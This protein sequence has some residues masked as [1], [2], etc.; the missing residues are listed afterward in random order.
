[1]STARPRAELQE[2]LQLVEQDLTQLRETAAS[3]RGR[4]GERWD[5]PTDS[6]E[7]SALIEAA[8]E[9]DLLIDRLE[10]RREELLR[11]LGEGQ[12]LSGRPYSC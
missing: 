12:G 8:E 9:Q 1:M 7:R 6:E 5:E 10:A 4:I 3:L 11:Y 2:E